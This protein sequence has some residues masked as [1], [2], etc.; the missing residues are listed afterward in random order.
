MGWQVTGVGFLAERVTTFMLP[1][2]PSRYPLGLGS[3]AGHEAR[4]RGQSNE[5]GVAVLIMEPI[6]RFLQLLCENHNRDL[7]VSV[8]QGNQGHVGPC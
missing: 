3:R 1:S 6:L 8:L 7:Q 4:D 5:M 2:A